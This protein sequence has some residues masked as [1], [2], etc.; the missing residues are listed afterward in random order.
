MI[1]HSRAF[2]VGLF[3]LLGILLRQGSAQDDSPTRAQ[4]I[5]ATLYTLLH[6]MALP[7]L[8]ESTN[9][10]QRFV[11]QIPGKVLYYYDYYPG[12]KYETAVQNQGDNSRPEVNVPPHIMENWFTLSDAV[13]GADP[14]TGGENGQQFSQQYSATINQ[15]EVRGF[16]TLTKEDKERYQQ[17]I[18]FLTEIVK[19]PND[20]LNVT[21]RYTLY[22]Q[23]QLEYYDKLSQLKNLEAEMQ[24]KLNAIDYEVWFQANYWKYEAQVEAA[25]G[26]WLVFGQKGIV[27]DYLS[28]LDVE[29]HG[30]A[31]EQA[32]MALRA[33]GVPSLDGSSTDYPVS[34]TPSNWYQYLLP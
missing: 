21:E 33:A 14:L 18:S 19:N 28:Y 20:P 15:V 25:Y 24:K 2:I 29:A 22:L 4:K 9:Q 16:S 34:F 3:F 26:A 30:E 10:A 32:R 8:N 31:A 1:Q 23:Y 6:N 11:L 7:N 12:S 13:P 27:E 5:Q 17:A